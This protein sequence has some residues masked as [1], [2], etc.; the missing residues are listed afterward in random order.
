MHDFGEGLTD[1]RVEGNALALVEGAFARLYIDDRIEKLYQPHWKEVKP[2]YIQQARGLV[3]VH[4][5]L[6]HKIITGKLRF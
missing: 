2:V 3:H 1:E 5:L 6:E 4:D